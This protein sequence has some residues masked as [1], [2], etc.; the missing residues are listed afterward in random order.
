MKCGIS[1]ICKNNHNMQEKYA[2][3]HGFKIGYFVVLILKMES[4][5]IK[6]NKTRKKCVDFYNKALGRAQ[7][8]EETA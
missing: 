3:K 8:K 1:C 6:H 2:Q 7:K 5:T 4:N